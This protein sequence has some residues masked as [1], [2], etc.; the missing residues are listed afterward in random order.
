MRLLAV[1]EAADL[2][3]GSL[4]ERLLHDFNLLDLGELVDMLVDIAEN[5]LLACFQLF[6]KLVLALLVPVDYI[7][8]ELDK[9]NKT[10]VPFE[11]NGLVHLIHIVDDILYLLRIDILA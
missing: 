3:G 4:L 10:P 11:D 2:L 5:G 7:V 8:I 6:E 1:F 9:G